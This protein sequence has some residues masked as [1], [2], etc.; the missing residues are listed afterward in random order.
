[1]NC[2][3]YELLSTLMALVHSIYVCKN[4]SNILYLIKNWNPLWNDS[5]VPH[6]RAEEW[7]CWFSFST[8]F[9]SDFLVSFL[10][11][12]M[13]HFVNRKGRAEARNC[14][15]TRDKPTIHDNDTITRWND[16]FCLKILWERE[17]EEKEGHIAEITVKYAFIIKMW[18]IKIYIINFIIF[19]LKSNLCQS[20][21][22]YRTLDLQFDIIMIQLL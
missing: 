2:L 17:R 13:K 19:L 1:M 11:N 15:F 20:A 9:V 8:L 3:R 4:A 5:I 16:V 6:F 22:R 10:G 7:F 12:T 21:G 18:I 14:R